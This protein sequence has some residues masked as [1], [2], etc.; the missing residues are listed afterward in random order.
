MTLFRLRNS[1]TNP[2]TTVVTSPATVTSIDADGTVSI[3]LGGGRV[4]DR[5]AVLASYSPAT[6]DVVEVVRRDSSTWLVLGAVRTSNATT[7]GVGSSLAFSFNVAPKPPPPPSDPVNPTANPWPKLAT[8]SASWRDNEGW[9]KTQAYQGSYNTQWGYH[10][11]C[12]FYGANAFAPLAGVTVTK[13]QIYLARAGIGGQGGAVPMFIAPHVHATQP[14]TK[15]YFPASAVNV[16]S[17]AWNAWGDFDLPVSWGQAL[18]NGTYKGLGHLYLGTQWY[19]IQDPLSTDS[20]N[21]KLTIW[22][23]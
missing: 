10:R 11:G 6:G 16:G 8:A 21:G 19:S 18:I 17:L 1:L 12:F 22:W 5:C 2:D 23:R 15:P 20:S 9:Y 4:I 14:A 7:V 13:I 3:D